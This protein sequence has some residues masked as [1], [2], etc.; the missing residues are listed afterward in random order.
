MPKNLKGYQEAAKSGLAKVTSQRQQVAMADLEH[1]KRKAAFENAS[2]DVNRNLKAIETLLSEHAEFTAWRETHYA[3]MSDGSTS[4]ASML[5]QDV[6]TYINLLNSWSRRAE[7]ELKSAEMILKVHRDVLASSDSSQF[8]ITEHSSKLPEA[9]AQVDKFQ[10]QCVKIQADK[11]KAQVL[12]KNLA[13][14]N[15]ERSSLE[16]AKRDCETALVKAARDL[17]DKQLILNHHEEAYKLRRQELKDFQI[18]NGKPPNEEKE[19]K[20][21]AEARVKS[22]KA[23]LDAVKEARGGSIESAKENLTQMFALRKNGSI[24]KRETD[25]TRKA[26]KDI[27]ALKKTA[28]E[29]NYDDVKEKLALIFS[30]RTSPKPS[31][32]LMKNHFDCGTKVIEKGQQVVKPAT[33]QR[34]KLREEIGEQSSM[35]AKRK[36]IAH[37]FKR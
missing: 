24:D 28:S 35:D 21:I 5:Q 30:S 22:V 18:S 3:K 11:Q 10:Q 8:A 6:L 29:R 33:D 20:K 17:R 7:G 15:T 27:E 2:Q 34:E 26:Q 4:S 32:T 36:A 16:V 14:L 19:L 23:E 1:H 9:H 12:L 13:P 25:E 37:L 31:D